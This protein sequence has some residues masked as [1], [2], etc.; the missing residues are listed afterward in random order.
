MGVFLN[1]LLAQPFAELTQGQLAGIGGHDGGDQGNMR[2]PFRLTQATR[3]IFS[4]GSKDFMSCSVKEFF[5]SMVSP[6]SG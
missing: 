5:V 1:I 3:P 2:Q 6:L 4:A